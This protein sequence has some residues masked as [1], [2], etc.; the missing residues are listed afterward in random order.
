MKFRS[1]SKPCQ[2]DLN[3]CSSTGFE[4]TCTVEVFANNTR[5]TI[6]T[7]LTYLPTLCFNLGQVISRVWDTLVL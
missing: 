1:H 7:Y 4:F 3:L 5:L 6:L 2:I